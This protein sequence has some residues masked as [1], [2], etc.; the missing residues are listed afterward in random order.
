MRNDPGL[1]AHLRTIPGGW[2]AIAPEWALLRLRDHL[3]RSRPACQAV[4]AETSPAWLV[5]GDCAMKQGFYGT[6]YTRAPTRCQVLV[7]RGWRAR[8][9]QAEG[10]ELRLK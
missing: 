10:P 3:T 9:G 2:Q 4:R 5:G 1:T 6:E 7:E 8:E